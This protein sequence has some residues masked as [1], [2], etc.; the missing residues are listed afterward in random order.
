MDIDIFSGLL[1]PAQI[2]ELL[3]KDSD[4]LMV[5]DNKGKPQIS[6]L[7][8]SFFHALLD[9]TSFGRINR[10]MIDEMVAV[11]TFGAKKYAPHNWRKGGSWVGVAD[12]ALRHFLQG[13]GPDAESGVSHR[14]HFACNLAYLLEF[15]LH[16]LEHDDRFK[17]PEDTPLPS[18]PFVR[19]PQEMVLTNFLIW[20]EGGSRNYLLD[21]LFHLNAWYDDETVS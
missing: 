15:T 10:T 9:V 2:S 21:A 1:S 3:I 5:R 6:L 8:A 19:T 20:L 13:L 17:L 12:C 4:R 14:A 11:Q 18:I 7:P 16:H